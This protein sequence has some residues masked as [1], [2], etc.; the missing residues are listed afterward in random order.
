MQMEAESGSVRQL[1]HERERERARE[2]TPSAAKF[3]ICELNKRSQ[4]NGSEEEGWRGGVEGS[5]QPS[6]HGFL[7]DL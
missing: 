2:P 4:N 5:R 3:I 1:E 6:N 7:Y